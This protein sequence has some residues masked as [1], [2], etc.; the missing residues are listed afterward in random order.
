MTDYVPF[1]MQ[2]VG[3]KMNGGG[4][5]YMGLMGRRMIMK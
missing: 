3:R 5:S 1:G 2:L 4:Y